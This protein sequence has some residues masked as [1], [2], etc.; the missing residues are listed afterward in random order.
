MKKRFAVLVAAALLL[1]ALPTAQAETW[2]CP[3][4]G[5]KNS[6]NFCPVCGT[7]KPVNPSS[8]SGWSWNSGL[9]YYRSLTNT[10]QTLYID[11]LEKGQYIVEYDFYVNNAGTYINAPTTIQ[12]LY[13]PEFRALAPANRLTVTK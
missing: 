12:C 7:A 8:P 4:C 6:L 13:A 5:A 10:A 1:A 2:Y 11:R 3:Q 9:S